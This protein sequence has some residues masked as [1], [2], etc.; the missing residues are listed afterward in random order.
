MCTWERN[1]DGTGGLA[2]GR[3][4]GRAPRDTPT[5]WTAWEGLGPRPWGCEPE[6]QVLATRSP[7]PS[8]LAR[9]R[10]Q[11]GGGAPLCHRTLWDLLLRSPQVT[12]SEAPT[13]VWKEVVD[14]G[15]DDILKA[16]LS[17]LKGLVFA[18]HFY[19]ETAVLLEQGNL[20]FVLKRRP[21]GS[22]GAAEAPN[23]EPRRQHKRMSAW[24]P[25]LRHPPTRLDPGANDSNKNSSHVRAGIPGDYYFIL[26]ITAIT[27]RT[28]GLKIC[29]TPRQCRNRYWSPSKGCMWPGHSA[30][31][32]LAPPCDPPVSLLRVHITCSSKDTGQN[33]P[34]GFGHDG[35]KGGNGTNVRQQGRGE[36]GGGRCARQNTATPRRRHSEGTAVYAA[37]WLGPTG[38]TT[39]SR[40]PKWM[41]HFCQVQEWVPPVSTG[42]RPEDG[43]FLW[44]E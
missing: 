41:T 43:Y 14:T 28:R 23:R 27:R 3:A 1:R 15:S 35:K 38:S 40:N 33:V 7:L 24:D 31:R 17:P 13:L 21:S 19:P 30:N 32:A 39:G 37:A 16:K 4:P 5:V 11:R 9:A 44:G 42:Q 34:N 22:P 18:K 20:L 2:A 12:T 26:A 29:V 8:A 10:W 25:P 36:T 6:T